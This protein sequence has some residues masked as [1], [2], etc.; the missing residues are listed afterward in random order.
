MFRMLVQYFVIDQDW[1]KK[2]EDWIG[3]EWE[4]RLE[5]WIGTGDTLKKYFSGN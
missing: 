3:P 2:L 4:D 5:E 1:E